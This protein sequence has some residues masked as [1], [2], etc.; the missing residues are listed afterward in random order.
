LNGSGNGGIARRLVAG[1]LAGTGRRGIRRQR[2]RI[3]GPSV[4]ARRRGAILGRRAR[5][6][7]IGRPVFPARTRRI[8]FFQE[9]EHKLRLYT[10][11]SKRQ[12]RAEARA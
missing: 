3:I 4:L 12:T 10:N 1:S 9:T 6:K 5:R 11:S 7:R 2:R 8:L